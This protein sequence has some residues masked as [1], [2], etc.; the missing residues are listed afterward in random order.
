M[1][2]YKKQTYFLVK[3]E[4]SQPSTL[5]IKGVKGVKGIKAN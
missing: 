3:V 1:F 2:A 5:F 4:S